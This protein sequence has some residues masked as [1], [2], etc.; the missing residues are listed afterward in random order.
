MRRRGNEFARLGKFGLIA[1]AVS[2]VLAS[3]TAAPHPIAR[4]LPSATAVPLDIPGE[5][6]LRAGVRLTKCLPGTGS[7]WQASGT[8]YN[9]TAEAQTYRITVF[10]TN[11]FA[12]VTG[13]ATTR[14]RVARGARSTWRATGNVERF[15]PTLCVLRGVG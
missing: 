5:P 11:R 2:V 9:A 6:G 10:F 15:T 12:T 13:F 1:I 8:I 14:V 3:C 7:T 4:P